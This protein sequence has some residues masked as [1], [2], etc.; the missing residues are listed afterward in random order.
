M[1]GWRRVH[2]SG[3]TADRLPVSIHEAFD[4][5]T[6]A[7]TAITGFA[8]ALQF[9]VGDNSPGG[10]IR[11]NGTTMMIGWPMSSPRVSANATASPSRQGRIY[12]FGDSVDVGLIVPQDGRD[13]EQTVQEKEMGN[14]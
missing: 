14:A 11:W 7:R 3:R 6:A 13:V 2:I 10:A 8:S 9:A 4:P 5:M 12:L 1:P